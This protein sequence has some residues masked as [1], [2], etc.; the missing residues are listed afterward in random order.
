[1]N[2]RK[3]GKELL[4]LLQQSNRFMLEKL[5]GYG[6]QANRCFGSQQT[7]QAAAQRRGGLYHEEYNFPFLSAL[8]S[9]ASKK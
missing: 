4:V 8:A 2:E 5:S 1:M 6:S 3:K 9:S 7:R